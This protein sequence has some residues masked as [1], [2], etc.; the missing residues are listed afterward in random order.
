MKPYVDG[1]VRGDHINQFLGRSKFDENQMLV[2]RRHIAGCP[3]C[4][5]AIDAARRH[6]NKSTHTMNYNPRH[7]VHRG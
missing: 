1:H 6:L 7:A 3:D 5:A 4:R 2:A